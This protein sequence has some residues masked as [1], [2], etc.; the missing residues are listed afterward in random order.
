LHHVD[1]LV[2][3][4]QVFDG[5]PAYVAVWDLPKSLTIPRSTNDVTQIDVHPAIAVDKMAVVS[6]TIL[7][8]DQHGA[9]DSGLEE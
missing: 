3:D 4:T 2:R 9:A 8:L 1:D 5:V 6:L 7:Q